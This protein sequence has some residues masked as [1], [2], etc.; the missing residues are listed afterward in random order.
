MT[1]LAHISDVHLGPLPPVRLRE[2]AS[3]R[4]FGYFNWHRNRARIFEPGILDAITE[5]IRASNP[6]HIAVTGDLVNIGLDAEYDAA[7]EWLHTL[8]D[9]Y[10]VTVVPGNHDAYVRRAVERYST[11]WL[12]FASG[13]DP[14][15]SMMFPFLR[16]RGPLALIGVSTAVATA[17]M[18]AT[19]RIEEEQAQK[20][21]QLLASTGREGLC[22]VVLI[23]HPPVSAR[24]N[25]FRRLIG[26]DL[27]RHAI[28]RFGAELLL[29]GH[30]HHTSIAYLPG[31]Q[32]TEVPVVGAATPSIMP[33]ERHPGAAYNLLQIEGEPGAWAIGMVERGFRDGAI[34]T[35]ASHRLDRPL[36]QP[37]ATQ[38]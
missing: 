36:D 20:L 29:H 23:H 31:A 34:R 16:R 33:H 1:V 18:M 6:D 17:P 25:W 32:G 7:L 8:G 24:S 19:G 38:A 28:A 27:V 11:A 21:G 12:P 30:D 5:D 3:K 35:V 4:A 26:A 10:N 37:T 13:D 2:L 22:R 9:P 15:P 14:H